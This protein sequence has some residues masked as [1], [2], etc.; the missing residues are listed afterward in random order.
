MRRRG[1]ILPAGLL[2]AWCAACAGGARPPALAPARAAAGAPG[3]RA[4]AVPRAGL[5]LVV[6]PADAEVEIDGVHRG[7]ASAL[8]AKTGGVVAL[9]AGVHRVSIRRDGYQTWRAEVAVGAAVER[10]EVRLV[11]GR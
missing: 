5:R 1:T 7:L 10:I 3:P 9:P 6:A 11:E 8:A 2:V 4:P